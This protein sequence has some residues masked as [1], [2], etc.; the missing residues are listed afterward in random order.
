MGAR[1]LPL[2]D[3]CL[4]YSVSH[5]L[6]VIVYGLSTCLKIKL[7]LLNQIEIKFT[8]PNSKLLLRIS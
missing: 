8:N 1:L 7:L 6:I 5:L 3:Y 4:Y 2:L